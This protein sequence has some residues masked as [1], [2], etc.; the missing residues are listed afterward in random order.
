VAILT[1]AFSVTGG[2]IAPRHVGGVEQGPVTG[3][4][5]MRPT[6]RRRYQSQNP[7]GRLRYVGLVACCEHHDARC[8]ACPIIENVTRRPL[9][10]RSA[11]ATPSLSAGHWCDEFRTGDWG[12]RVDVDTTHCAA[13]RNATGPPDWYACPNL[14]DQ[15]FTT[16]PVMRSFRCKKTEPFE[17]RFGP[18]SDQH[19]RHHHR[20]RPRSL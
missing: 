8:A 9:R 6:A 20:H 12:A 18:S 3:G 17:Y 15:R 10:L 5:G 4:W 13:A 16:G 7:D 19:R 1:K 14:P 2:D 11:D